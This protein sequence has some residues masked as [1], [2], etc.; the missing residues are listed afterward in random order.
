[1]SEH[2]I[3]SNPASG[4]YCILMIWHKALLISLITS[5]KFQKIRKKGV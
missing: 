3:I 1:V 2:L 4:C 5:T